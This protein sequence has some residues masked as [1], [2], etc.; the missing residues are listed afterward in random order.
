MPMSEMQTD[1]M[2]GYALGSHVDLDGGPEPHH[3]F[4]LDMPGCG[5]R[6][7]TYQEAR[8]RLIALWPVFRGSIQARGVEV[9]P[10]KSVPA[11][12]VGSIMVLRGLNLRP[13][14]MSRETD[15]PASTENPQLVTTG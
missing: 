4:L 10:P 9:P 14:L 8:E 1:H 3:V 7:A 15:R 13:V 2:D 6:G 12:S 11:V 5:T